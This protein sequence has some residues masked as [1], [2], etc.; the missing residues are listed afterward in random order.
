M[1]RT[2]RE[3]HRHTHL[4]AD[5]THRHKCT[6]W[7]FNQY[8]VIDWQGQKIPGGAWLLGDPIS[9]PSR[10]GKTNTTADW[11]L[12]FHSWGYLAK[13]L[14]DISGLL[15]VLLKAASFSDL[16]GR[17]WLNPLGPRAVFFLHSNLPPS[18]PCCF[19]PDLDQAFRQRNEDTNSKDRVCPGNG[20]LMLL[21]S[22][23]DF[24]WILSN[25][26]F[27]SWIAGQGLR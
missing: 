25:F 27:F 8:W 1:C 2:Q 6:V 7:I 11:P 20:F 13:L 23:A 21:V 9:Q 3:R 12:P 14:L 26:M 4:Y 16:P 17:T 18:A 15:R 24:T 5:N 10:C 19:Q 22:K